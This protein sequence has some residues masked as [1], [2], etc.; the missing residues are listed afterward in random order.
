MLAKLSIVE[1]E[2]DEAGYRLELLASN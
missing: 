2:A 1:E